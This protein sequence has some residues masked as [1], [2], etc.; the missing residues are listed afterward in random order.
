MAVSIDALAGIAAIDAA[1]EGGSDSAGLYDPT[2]PATAATAE[3]LYAN[4]KAAMKAAGVSFW[5][6]SL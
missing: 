3:E 1:N 5:H 4:R 6:K 2:K